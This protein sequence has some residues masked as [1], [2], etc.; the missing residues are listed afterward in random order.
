ME[1]ALIVIDAQ[2]AFD[3]GGMP[4]HNNPAVWSNIAA[5]LDAWQQAN[6]PIVLVRHD[7]REPGSPLAPGAPGNA[8][9]AELANVEPDLLVTKHVNSA[10]HGTVDL[11]GWL[12][13]LDIGQIVL[14]G[15]TTNH[16]V[17]TTARVGGNLG[18]DV[19]VAIDATGAFAGTD[20]DG[21]VVS[22]DE[23]TRATVTNL[24]S[25]GFASI[26]STSEAIRRSAPSQPL[27][28]RLL[29]P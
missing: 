5:L 11:H 13:A 27:F 18:Y 7:S 6:R 12:A 3:D 4:R 2:R 21:R 16:C 10:F 1:P 15:L 19:V 26:S 23:L 8:F 28:G 24:H 14:C 17:E 29:R 25:G 22:A 20:P 9:V